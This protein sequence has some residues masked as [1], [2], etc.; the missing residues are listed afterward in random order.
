[1]E[2]R[3]MGENLKVMFFQLYIQ[4]Y[5]DV[6]PTE[7]LLYVYLHVWISLHMLEGMSEIYRKNPG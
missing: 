6:R 4:T 3:F 1:M 5:P 2:L 7:I